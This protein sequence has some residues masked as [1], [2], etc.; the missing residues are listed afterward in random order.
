M[1]CAPVCILMLTQTRCTH[2]R[3]RMVQNP[4]RFFLSPHSEE[5]GDPFR[6]SALELLIS[7]GL[8]ASIPFHYRPSLLSRGI[9]G[10][11]FCSYFGVHT[12]LCT[13]MFRGGAR[14]G[15]CFSKHCIHWAEHCSSTYL[16]E[17]FPSRHFFTTWRMA[18]WRSNTSLK[19]YLFP[20]AL[21]HSARGAD[22]IDRHK[23][24][25]TIAGCLCHNYG[26]C[27]WFEAVGSE[28]TFEIGYQSTRDEDIDGSYK[29]FFTLFESLWNVM[30]LFDFV[31]NVLESITQKCDVLWKV[32]WNV[33][34]EFRFT[35]FISDTRIFWDPYKCS[36]KKTN[37]R[38]LS[39]KVERVTLIKKNPF[40]F[41]W[42]HF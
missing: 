23:S 13:E 11:G 2:P 20:L 18:S 33:G 1:W 21:A 8:C 39:K 6:V 3:P 31:L 37:T 14:G 5:P 16:M 28:R 38:F 34:F 26:Q 41:E 29:A 25:I 10:N 30:K 17:V 12:Y 19:M 9:E 36:T 7:L 22:E 24:C 15:V 35:C 27:C 42:Y 32:L 4:P 40:N